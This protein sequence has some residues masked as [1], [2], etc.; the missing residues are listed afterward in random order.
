[1]STVLHELPWG[2]I[3]IH[4]DNEVRIRTTKRDPVKLRLAIPRDLLEGNVGA[5]SFDLLDGDRSDEI[6][7]VGCRVDA[8]GRATVYVSLKLPGASEVTEVIHVDPDRA[9]FAIPIEAPN[10]GV[11][12]HNRLESERY[13][14]QVQDDPPHLPYGS[15]IVYDKQTGQP[16]AQLK[17]V[18]AFTP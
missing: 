12:T 4:G 7:Q 8:L 9:F 14:Y 5:V 6:A 17:P 18:Q 16:V 11:R 15:I 2:V 13:L 10:V 1:M 3:E